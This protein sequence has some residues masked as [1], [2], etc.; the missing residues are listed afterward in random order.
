[1]KI[2]GT[3]LAVAIVLAVPALG[4]EVKHAPTVAQC[5]ADQKLWLSKLEDD[6]GIDDVKFET[7]D[8]WQQE[9]KDCKEVDEINGRKYFN[10]MT[11]IEAE[12]SRRELDFIVRHHQFDQFLAEDAAGQR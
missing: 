4:Q 11:E 7:L 3:L 2:K 5:Q 1:M 12:F 6:R 8:G 10:V 9:M